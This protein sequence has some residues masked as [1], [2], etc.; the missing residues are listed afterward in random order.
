[1]MLCTVMITE[2]NTS[3]ASLYL[4]KGEL[5]RVLNRWSKSDCYTRGPSS[6]QGH[7]YAMP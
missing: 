6:L 7:A 3:I 2:V 1:M 4:W 5:T